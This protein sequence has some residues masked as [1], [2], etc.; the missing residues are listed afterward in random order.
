MGEGGGLTYDA[1]VLA[2]AKTIPGLVHALDVRIAPAQ[3][4]HVRRAE[5]LVAPLLR[6]LLVEVFRLGREEDVVVSGLVEGIEEVLAFAA[7]RSVSIFIIGRVRRIGGGGEGERT[8]PW[9]LNQGV[10]KAD[11][12]CAIASAAWEAKRSSF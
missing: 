12:F 9:A 3:Q 11:F 8:L 4:R 7:D 5:A 2:H 10:S 6:R 1:I